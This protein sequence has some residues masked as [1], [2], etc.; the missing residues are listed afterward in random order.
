MGEKADPRQAAT[1]EE[2]LRAY[3][4]EYEQKALLRVPVRKGLVDGDTIPVCWIHL[5][6]AE[7]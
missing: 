3:L 1:F 2:L 4:Y 5:H 6:Y 7:R